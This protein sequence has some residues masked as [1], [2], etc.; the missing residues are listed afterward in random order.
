MNEREAY[1]A[2]NMME[3]VG[4][5]GVRSLVEA[6][7]S[8]VEIFSAGR[9][10]LRGAWGGGR[11]LADAILSQRDSVQWQDEMERAAS[12][13]IRILT[14]I[15]PEYPARLKEIH[16]PPLA[17]YVKG[18]IESRDR[19][20]VAVVGTRHPT[21]YGRD[22][23]E[24]LS[25][26][27][28]AAGITVVSG[29]AEGID[30]TAHRAALKAG[31]RTLAV[32]GSG[33]DHVYPVSNRDLAD[34]IRENGAV[35][36]EFPLARQPDKTTFPIRNRI[37]SGLSLGVLVVEAGV[38]SGAL[39][40][41]QQA[42]E[43]GR[44]VM[45]VPG[46]IDIPTSQATNDL[47]KD[48]AKLVSCV[49]DILGEFECLIPVAEVRGSGVVRKPAPALSSDEHRLVEI[50][51]GGEQDV[52]SLIRLS[53]LGPASVNALLVGLEMKRCVRMLPGRMVERQR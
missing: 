27:L 39:I 15:D 52:D 40:T 7:G 19:H 53:G 21:H 20:S 8:A 6:L 47:I 3:K 2:L 36:S 23:A 18:G 46:R 13:G 9:D 17:L 24:R 22:V 10:S 4:P 41:V 26:Q 12:S 32:I 5:V 16:D 31:G 34:A 29:L 14:Q 38:K 37:V 35:I 49:E 42:M 51:D 48:G 28:A 43:Q 45:A 25:G 44:T 50:L 30:T 33:M 11:D 1:V